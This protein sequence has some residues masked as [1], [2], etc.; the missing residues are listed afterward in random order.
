MIIRLDLFG[1][2]LRD[3]F[4]DDSDID[5]LATFAADSHWSLMDLVTM[6]QELTSIVG[7]KVDLIERVSIERSHNPLRRK[8]ILST[9]KPY[10]A[11]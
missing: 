6:E 9:A 1:S 5:F 8:E 11:A 3:D 10:Y 4:R 2:A 7:R